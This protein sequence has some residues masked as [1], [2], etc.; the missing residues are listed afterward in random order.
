MKEKIGNV[1]LDYTYYPGKDLYSDGEVEEE[2][3]EISEKYQENQWNRVIAEKKSWPV[4]Y[5]YSHIRQNIVEWLPIGKKDTVLE[6]GAGCG[7]ITGVLA[8]KAESVT[9]IELSKRRS[10]IN[11]NRNK[12][13]DNIE[14]L[15]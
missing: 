5:H 2:L 9:C 11:A 7:A 14:I 15:V 3:L 12:K 10:L 6:I 1:V 13:Y 8:K 4:M